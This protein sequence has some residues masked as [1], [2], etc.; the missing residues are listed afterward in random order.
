MAIS[1]KDVEHIARLARIELRPQEREQF[2]KELSGILEFA[3][4][5][6]E[7]D[8]FNVLPLSGGTALENVMREDERPGEEP[9]SRKEGLVEVSPQHHD[10][11]I[12]V[13]PVFERK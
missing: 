12:E 6:N 10:G 13:K 9:G 8:T 5:L 4:K 3:E 1:R 11:Y 2:E 7:L